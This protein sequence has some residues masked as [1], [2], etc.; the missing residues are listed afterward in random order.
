MRKALFI[1]MMI[2]GGN[3]GIQLKGQIPTPGLEKALAEQIKQN[4]LSFIYGSEV[5]EFYKNHDHNT[6]WITNDV[7]RQYLL[8]YL[9][10]AADFGLSKHD[11]QFNFIESFRANSFR[12][13][14]SADSIEA[15]IRFTDAGIHFFNDVVNGNHPPQIGYNGLGYDPDCVNIPL[16]LSSA[17][18]QNRF[19][20]FLHEIEDKSP[21]YVALKNKIIHYN[22]IIRD[23]LYKKDIRITSAVLNEGNKPLLQKLFQLGIIE[24]PSGKIAEKDIKQKLKEAQR[25]FSLMDDGVLRWPVLAELNVP[26]VSRLEALFRAINTVRWLRCIREQA[27][28]IVVVN[29]PSATLL[30]YGHT[31]VTM[32]SK[33]IVGK[34]ST[35]TPV[36][37]SKISEV[38]LYPYWMV[39][40]SIAT[41]ELLPIIKRNT[42]YLEANSYQVVNEQG[43]V[44]NPSTINW[45][46]LSAN[47]FPYTLR[48]STGCDNSLGLIKLNFYSPYGVYLHDTPGKSLFSLNKRYF[49][50]GCIRVEKAIGLAHVA[51]KNNTIAI[52]TLEEKG[53]L[54]N[55]K[56]IP[57][58]VA[59][60]IPVFVLYN[61]A[62]VDSSA[63]VRFYEDVYNKFSLNRQ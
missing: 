33:V 21:E 61:T 40:K 3:A 60:K 45:Q 59:G 6:A 37:C 10:T 44:V 53:C 63:T 49:S 5:E 18:V 22:R 9:E 23:T 58:P 24:S 27:T 8:N 31:S 11:Y 34:R 20:G 28:D 32:E 57:V 17:L 26:M 47:Y 50:H 42:S 30:V 29:I 16:L 38:V 35:R 39:P 36:F 56:P 51:L 1:I 19:Q 62:W 14:T 43:R 48:Q 25:L 15:E 13:A 46:A 12:L 41:K 52:D 7:N 54:R 55:Q 2:V 4:A